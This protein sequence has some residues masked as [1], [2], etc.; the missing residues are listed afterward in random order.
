SMDQL[1]PYVE[2][3][4]QL[5]NSYEKDIRIRVG[6]EVDFIAGYE[7]EIRSFLNDIGPSLDDAILSVHFLQADNRSF[8]ADFSKEVFAELAT[9]SDSVMAAYQLYYA[10]VEASIKADLG[11]FKPRRIGHPTVIH[12]FQL[13]HGEKID[14]SAQIRHILQSM[15]TA[16]CELDVNGAGFSKPD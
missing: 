1:M 16:G 13:A 12:K 10:T 5:K 3:I 4:T 15:K 2:E 7:N 6:L 14:D 9:A 8:C 11:P